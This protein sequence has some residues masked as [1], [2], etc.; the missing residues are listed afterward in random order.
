MATNIAPPLPLKAL[1]IKLGVASPESSL[2]K[3]EHPSSPPPLTEDNSG[4]L[5]DG[6]IDEQQGAVGSLQGQLSYI[7]SFLTNTIAGEL[8]LS[9]FE[10]SALKDRYKRL[11]RQ[12]SELQDLASAYSECIRGF[13]ATNGQTVSIDQLQAEAGREGLR[14]KALEADVLR[15]LV[16]E[17][18]GIQALISQTSTMRTI[19][20]KA[21]GLRELELFVSD[22][23]TIRDTL[24]ELRG[25]RGLL[26]LPEE[27][28][29]LL[30][31]K[32]Q[33]DGLASE[34]DGP[35]GL[36]EKAAKYEKLTKAFADEQNASTIRRPAISDAAMNPARARMISA[37]PLDTDPNRDLYEAPPPVAEPNNRTGSNNTPLGALQD[38]PLAFTLKRKNPENPAS[39]IP[40][41]RLR[42]DV[43]RAST[44]LQ[45]SLS[46]S[47]GKST[48]PAA[49]HEN[50]SGKQ[51]GVNLRAE[52][53][54]STHFEATE[55]KDGNALFISGVNVEEEAMA[56]LAAEDWP[57][58]VN[59]QK[60]KHFFVAHFNSYA[61]MWAA[62]E[63][64]AADVKNTRGGPNKPSVKVF[65]ERGKPGR[66]ADVTVDVHIPESL[67]GRSSNVEIEGKPSSCPFASEVEGR[68]VKTDTLDAAIQ[69]HTAAPPTKMPDWMRTEVRFGHVGFS[70]A[71]GAPRY[72]S[73]PTAQDVESHADARLG[74]VRFSTDVP[75]LP[76]F[77]SHASGIVGGAHTAL[78]PVV[79]VP[80][81]P[82]LDRM[83]ILKDFLHA[84]A[85]WVGTSDAPTAWDAY[86]LKR[87]FQ[88]PGDLLASLTGQLSR[89]IPIAKYSVYE[90]MAPNHDTCILR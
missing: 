66:F 25:S 33:L 4:V 38:Q 23:R 80:A 29:D 48:N 79:A 90:T 55:R 62:L 36:R 13:S 10:Y 5:D 41:K 7:E 73:T 51:S 72:S 45:A 82:R 39:S 24:D 61:E 12:H 54:S 22:L 57:G 68:S 76:A 42:V 86:Q 9:N 21:G 49:G 14:A 50:S 64:V 60:I 87:N 81:D 37:T 67:L 56:L 63:R 74:P 2:V 30:E 28:R 15:P 32:Q 85:F 58:I 71:A 20:D 47:V 1:A 70:S 6:E 43:G 84:V 78:Q 16:R 8:Q 46:A 69:A 35:N 89:L 65:N 3:V 19:I 27:V 11:E 75:S 83:T 59:L 44:V 31:S 53:T 18:G 88:I 34:V 26:G 52:S 40:V 77:S 17:T